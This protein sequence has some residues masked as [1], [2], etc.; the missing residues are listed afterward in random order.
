MKCV[1]PKMRLAPVGISSRIALS[2]HG[3]FLGYYL[4]HYRGLRPPDRRR[5]AGLHRAAAHGRATY[6]HLARVLGAARGPEGSTG[7]PGARGELIE[8]RTGQFELARMSRE[9]RRRAAQ[10]SSRRV[11]LRDP[12]TRV[13]SGSPATSSFRRRRPK[14]HARR[15]RS[16]AA[17]A[18]HRGRP[19]GGEIVR[20]IERAHP[21]VV[22]EFHIRGESRCAIPHDERPPPLD[23]DPRRTGQ[24]G[25]GG[26]RVEV[27]FLDYP[28][29]GGGRGGRVI[30]VLGR[31]TTSVSMSR[32][33]S[34]SPHPAPLSAEVLDQA[35]RIEETISGR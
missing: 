27:E 9:L 17:G 3:D 6:R 25:R 33:S 22:G 16:G 24:G 1:C 13:R 5:A 20:V 21:T 2:F 14:G 26:R 7:A 19:R 11:R 32:S 10:C 29:K 15:P 35:Q 34:V 30:E 18:R 31:P 28:E 4:H 23:R 8:T 12:G